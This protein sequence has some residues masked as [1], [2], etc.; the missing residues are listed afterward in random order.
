MKNSILNLL[1]ISV[2]LLIVG[3]NKHESIEP[4]LTELHQKGKFNGNVLVIKGGKTLY[5]N[6]FGYADATKTDL[7][8]KD[9]R[10]DIGS[11]YKEFPAT[12]IMQLQEKGKLK[13][14]DKISKYLSH[15][16]SWSNSI[17]IEHLMQYSSGLPQIE[18]DEYFGNGI[19]ITDDHLI[20]SLKDIETLEFDAGSDYLYSNNNPILL[21]KII[22]S[23]SGL[24]YEDYLKAN[25]FGTVNM[26]NTVFK[27]Q[28]PYLDKTLM[29]IPFSSDFEQDDYNIAVRNM[30]I[31]S[32]ARDLANWLEQLGNYSVV[33]KTSV[34]QLS[35]E[36]TSGFNIQSPLGL[37]D[38][39]KDTITEHSHHGSSGN[40]ECVVRRFK[41]DDI[42]I[43]ILTN[44]K[45][46]NVYDISDDIYDIIK[47]EGNN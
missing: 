21:I 32:T 35:K 22:E 19:T 24:S 12:A 36:A 43:I 40:F 18:W 8:T 27:D 33:S 46:E 45:H 15:F 44:Q 4:Y 41:Q 26:S 42:I 47:L 39:E 31:T 5:E 9:H 7:L 29:A 17:T 30:L 25:I 10:F 28:Y 20:Q 38:W 23:I 1:I 14:D 37:C 11:V 3:C 16:P 13:L 2:C 34:Q 6:S